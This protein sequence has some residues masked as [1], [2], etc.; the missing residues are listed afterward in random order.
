MQPSQISNFAPNFTHMIACQL[1]DFCASVGAAVDKTKQLADLLDGEAEIAAAP[2]EVE[3][4][5]EIPAIEAVAAS[6][7]DGGANRPT[8]S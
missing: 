6:A 1:L 8:C 4:P 3:A 2:D 7:A 5:N